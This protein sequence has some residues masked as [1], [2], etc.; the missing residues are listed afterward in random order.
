MSSVQ[1]LLTVLMMKFQGLFLFSGE[2][3]Y[4]TNDIR[5]VLVLEPM[6]SVMV[7]ISD[8]NE[9]PVFCIDCSAVQLLTVPKRNK[10]VMCAMD[11][12]Y[13]DLNSIDS[14]NIGAVEVFEKSHE[15]KY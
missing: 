4:E 14:V 3:V 13:G 1:T 15:M 9:L 5:E 6:Q 7:S 2:S 8:L 10:T 12:L 11:E